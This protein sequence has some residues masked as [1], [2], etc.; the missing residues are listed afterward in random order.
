MCHSSPLRPKPS[1]ATA[2]SVNCFRTLASPGSSEDCTSTVDSSCGAGMPWLSGDGDVD[3][4][5]STSSEMMDLQSLLQPSQSS[6]LLQ[7]SS[8][9]PSSQLTI[10]PTSLS[11]PSLLSPT[12]TT[13]LVNQTAA[14][15]TVPLNTDNTKPSSKLLLVHKTPET[16]STTLQ[17]KV[18]TQE[19]QESSS[20]TKTTGSLLRNA[21]TAGKFVNKN[22][23]ASLLNNNNNNNGSSL[24]P[25]I[26]KPLPSVPVQ[27][28]ARTYTDK[29]SPQ[30]V[31]EI[32]L[33]AMKKTGTLD[34]VGQQPK[35][36]TAPAAPS[37]PTAIITQ[38]SLTTLIPV[39]VHEDRNNNLKRG[40]QAVA[41][42]AAAM[43][44][45]TTPTHT[46]VPTTTTT[47]PPPNKVI[48]LVLE[49]PNRNINLLEPVLPTQP[50]SLVEDDTEDEK[51]AKRPM[52]SPLGAGCDRQRETP[53]LLHYCHICN[54]GF[55]D[56]YSVNVHVR[57]HTGEKPF[58]CPLCGKCF[59]QK[60][61]LAKH[62]QTHAAKPPGGQQP[63]PVEGLPP[64]PP[65]PGRTSNT[66]ILPTQPEQLATLT[67]IVPKGLTV[68]AAASAGS[69][70]QECSSS[71][72]RSSSP[73][74]NNNPTT[75]SSLNSF[76]KKT[77]EGIKKTSKEGLVETSTPSDPQPKQI[78]LPL[79]QVNM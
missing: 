46:P 56:R 61:H 15:T 37:Q 45:S 77:L 75:S 3:D 54:K 65:Y 25:S 4:L 76:I 23:G 53:R 47:Q 9:K 12:S 49:G 44:T 8:F 69:S 7:P 2:A 41:S 42:T 27:V 30:K 48:S 38:P 34:T 1:P 18:T 68:T 57:T 26:L 70:M 14:T 19:D 40:F 31:E 59:R 64:P 35:L 13:S 21:L 73:T 74:N 10:S 63:N 67:T 50:L 24:T 58:S 78:I 66:P 62:H 39:S 11:Q 60:A 6:D 51:K 43:P 22:K 71:F 20:S 52:T 28:P 72:R 36:P 17:L 33:L 5:A 29:P 79:A 16:L 55:K 32:I